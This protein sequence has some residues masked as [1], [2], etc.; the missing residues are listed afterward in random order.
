MHGCDY[1][2]VSVLH[3]SFFPG[4][5]GPDGRN[6]FAPKH[7]IFIRGD[8]DDGQDRG[9]VLPVSFSRRRRKGQRIASQSGRSFLA[10]VILGE[11]APRGDR[12]LDKSMQ[13]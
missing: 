2:E 11:I 1:G 6:I 4:C 13:K 10:L 12:V 9:W 7:Q 5:E 3:V 8:R